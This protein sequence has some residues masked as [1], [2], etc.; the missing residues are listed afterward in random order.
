MM[1]KK[2]LF[3]LALALIVKSAVAG[4]LEEIN[5]LQK[6]IFQMK[7]QQEKLQQ[8]LQ[9]LQLKSQ[10]MSAT[11]SMS[12]TE[13][14]N[15]TQKIQQE[16]SLLQEKIE[17]EKAKLREAKELGQALMIHMPY[18]GTAMGKYVITDNG[19]IEAG[20][21]FGLGR[22]KIKHG[23]VK[24][25]PYYLTNEQIAQGGSSSPTAGGSMMGGSPMMGGPMGG[26]MPGHMSSANGGT[27]PSL[28]PLPPLASLIGNGSPPPQTPSQTPP[29]AGAVPPGAPPS[30]APPPASMPTAPHP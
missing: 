6:E 10:L 24:A 9:N 27:P 7:I 13:M 1:K 3:G 2:L 14:M 18:K 16:I 8:E 19:V 11:S 15:R 25:G 21:N 20:S 26:M 4:P 17:L 23:I 29:P 5:K 22:I 30:S 12:L 28:P